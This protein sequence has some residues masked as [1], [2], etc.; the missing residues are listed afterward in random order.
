MKLIFAGKCS[1]TSA[2]SPQTM[3]EDEPTLTAAEIAKLLYI[4]S[5]DL[6]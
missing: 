2:F 1:F 6:C 4:D 3:D 5:I